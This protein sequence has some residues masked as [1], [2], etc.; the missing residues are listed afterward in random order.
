MGISQQLKLHKFLISSCRLAI[1]QYR[2]W[3]HWRGRILRLSLKSMNCHICQTNWRCVWRNL[4]S[5]L[6]Y[7][8][9]CGASGWSNCLHLIH[10][11]EM[12][13][14][15]LCEGSV[16]DGSSTFGHCGS[17]ALYISTCIWYVHLSLLCV[18][19]TELV[20]DVLSSTTDSCRYFN[21]CCRVLLS[22]VV[23]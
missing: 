22:A 13:D 12:L 21:F 1:M 17:S 4:G 5:F 18:L 23:R 19:V 10:H 6:F 2:L 15:F 9:T 11:S 3:T 16:F 8:E 7:V 14:F 20:L